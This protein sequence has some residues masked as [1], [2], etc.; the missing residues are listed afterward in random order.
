MNREGR[1]DMS[2]VRGEK[3]RDCSPKISN[4]WC[5]CS[6]SAAESRKNDSGCIKEA[7]YMVF[8]TDASYKRFVTRRLHPGES[9]DHLFFVFWR[10]YGNSQFCSAIY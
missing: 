2:D 6:V 1:I 9:A 4:G 3:D 10:N 8:A 5:M 7:L